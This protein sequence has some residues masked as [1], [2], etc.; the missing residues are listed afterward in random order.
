MPQ[1]GRIRKAGFPV[2]ATGRLTTGVCDILHG[3]PGRRQDVRLR[4]PAGFVGM[5]CRCMC[6]PLPTLDPVACSIL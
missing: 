5:T 6:A 4:D 3:L 1:R 2:S